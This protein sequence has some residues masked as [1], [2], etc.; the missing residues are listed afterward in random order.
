MG[1]YGERSLPR[2]GDTVFL[3]VEN[4]G[5]TNYRCDVVEVVHPFK[6]RD[7]RITRDGLPSVLL[8]IKKE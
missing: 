5:T 6:K 7:G 1:V 2:V 3:E 4:D 8:N